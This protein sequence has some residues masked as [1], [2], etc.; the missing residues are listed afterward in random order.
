[1]SLASTSVPAAFMA[2]SM[3]TVVSS[4][5][6]DSNDSTSISTN[7]M[8]LF[9]KTAA[10]STFKDS[11]DSTL[12]TTISMALSHRSYLINMSDVALP[13]FL[14]L[15]SSLERLSLRDCQLHGEFPR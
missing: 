2:L 3:I 7:L 5:F 11:N 4:T 1:M 10:S 8:A 9:L 6:K 15:T 12:L 13:S 14:N